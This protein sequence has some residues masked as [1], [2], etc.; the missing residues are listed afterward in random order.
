MLS[1]KCQGLNASASASAVLLVGQR[2]NRVLLGRFV[3]RI[4]RACDR[5]QNGDNRCPQDPLTG[6]Y[7]A[8]G[9]AVVDA[10]T[11]RQAEQNPDYDPREGKQNCLPQNYVHDVEL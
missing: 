3:G 9:G 1:A 7:D 8:Q 2:V 4:E 11:S 6:D 10:H 5:S